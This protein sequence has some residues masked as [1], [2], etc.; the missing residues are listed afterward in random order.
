MPPVEDLLYK[1]WSGSV[2]LTEGV[3]SGIQSSSFC[4]RKNGP[5][6]DS[7][8]D[9]HMEVCTKPKPPLCKGRC[10]GGAVTEG[11]SQFKNYSNSRDHGDFFPCRKNSRKH[12]LPVIPDM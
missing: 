10:H 6:S 3:V 5:L 11:L 12:V 8:R 1:S 2:K 9:A 7:A 4:V